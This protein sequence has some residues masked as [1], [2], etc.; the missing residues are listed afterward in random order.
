LIVGTIALVVAL[1]GNAFAGEI[2]TIAKTVINGGS[3]KKHSITGSKLA[4]N[5]LTG[6]QINEA[7]LGTVPHAKLA[8]NAGNAAKLGGAA[9]GSYFP[10]SKMFRWNF[11]MNKGITLHTFGPFGP[12]TF[13][14]TCLADGVKTAAKLTVSTSETGTFVSSDTHSLPSSGGMIINPGDTYT[15]VQQDSATA[16][17]GN[18]APLT[19][20]DP[21]G[22]LAVFTTAETIGLAINTPGADCRFFGN[23]LNDA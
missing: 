4:K 1:G 8:D 15:V 19:A 10:A 16:N 20:F 23:L 21:Q 22:T 7:K 12:L 17:D 11:A 3:I 6:T 14:A 18:S 13:T 9:P 2:A 5:T